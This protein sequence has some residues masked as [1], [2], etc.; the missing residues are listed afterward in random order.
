MNV[1][2]KETIIAVMENGGRKKYSKDETGKKEG[3]ITAILK[4]GKALDVYV[5]PPDML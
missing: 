1:K 2:Y 4:C 3:K 5:M